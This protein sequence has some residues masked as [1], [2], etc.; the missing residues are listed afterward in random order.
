VTL[1]LLTPSPLV[2]DVSGVTDD[3]HVDLHGC[4]ETFADV[5]FDAF[6]NELH[7]DE[8]VN[9]DQTTTSPDQD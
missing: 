4:D 1:R 8:R 3:D 9:D 2:V 5:D 6:G 7:D